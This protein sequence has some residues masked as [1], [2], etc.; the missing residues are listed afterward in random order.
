MASAK[1][2]TEQAG[3][4]LG[5]VADGPCAGHGL[6]MGRSWAGHGQILG[7]LS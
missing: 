6:V 2:A 3:G 5:L 1:M 7:K 4:R